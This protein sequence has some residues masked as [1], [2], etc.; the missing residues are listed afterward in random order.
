MVTPAFAAT[1]KKRWDEIKAD[2]ESSAAAV[3]NNILLIGDYGSGKTTIL[4]TARRPLRVYCFDPGGA[5]VLQD[6]IDKDGNIL[7][8]NFIEKDRMN[9]TA[10]SGFKRV[11]MT[12]LSSGLLDAMGTVAIDS[13]TT[14]GSAILNWVVKYGSNCY[15]DINA[16][17]PNLKAYMVQ[18]M[19]VTDFV[20]K[21]AA[22]KCDVVLTA[23]IEYEKDEIAGD[24]QAFIGATKKMKLVLPPMF[25]EKWFCDVKPTSQGLVYSILTE[26][27]SRRVASTRMGAGGKLEKNEKPNIKA[28]LKKCGRPCEDVVMSVEEEVETPA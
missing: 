27:D 7:V 22:L 2:Y 15:A 10:F 5:S 23:H 25:D 26:K 6:D 4:R 20:Q 18:I 16:G 12:D 9:P 13:Y 1:M 24:L 14:W 28:I 17:I 19:E 8:T 3:K 11:F 21:L